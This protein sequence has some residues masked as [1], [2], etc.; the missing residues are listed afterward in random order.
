MFRISWKHG[1]LITLHWLLAVTKCNIAVIQILYLTRMYKAVVHT[2]PSKVLSALS[3]F[4]SSA[5]QVASLVIE[6]RGLNGI[7]T[8][9]YS[10][11]LERQQTWRQSSST[12]KAT[13]VGSSQ[14]CLGTSAGFSIFAAIAISVGI[15]NKL[16]AAHLCL[17]P[18]FPCL[19]SRWQSAGQ[20]DEITT[21]FQNVAS[22]LFMNIAD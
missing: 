20:W 8:A 22:K 17:F 4:I 1:I 16:L 5:E 10:C 13:V 15:E 18:P 7:S 11:C 6:I 2:P 12:V 14:R 3:E 9:F 19:S 21:P